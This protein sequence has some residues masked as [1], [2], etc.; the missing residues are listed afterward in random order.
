MKYRALIAKSASW[1]QALDYARTRP[2]KDAT[3][4]AGR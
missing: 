1:E 3:L 2:P 4:D